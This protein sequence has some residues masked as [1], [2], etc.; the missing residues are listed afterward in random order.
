MAQDQGAA[1]ETNSLMEATESP[2]DAM[3]DP[4]FDAQPEEPMD[5]TPSPANAM[6]AAATEE[7]QQQSLVTVALPADELAEGAF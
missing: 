5:A 6:E 3:A 4:E 1:A 7:A 2:N